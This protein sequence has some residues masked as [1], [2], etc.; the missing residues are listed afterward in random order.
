[1]NKIA[2]I[3]TG[4]AGLAVCWH[5]K[6]YFPNANIDLFNETSIY[7]NTSGASTGLLHGFI[8]KNARKSLYADDAMKAVLPLL[9]A[10]QKN[11]QMPLYNKGIYRIA[12]DKAQDMLFYEKSLKHLELQYFDKKAANI[13]FSNLVNHSGILIKNA[14]TINPIKYLK[15][16]F[17]DLQ[18][19]SVNFFQKKVFPND[20]SGYD[21]E[22][23]CTGHNIDFL[24]N[25]FPFEYEKIKGQM[26]ICKWPEG[27]PLLNCSICG[28]GH[29]SLI[30]Q[31]CYL[32]STY[33]HD[34]VNCDVNEKVNDVIEKI[35]IFFPKVEKLKI[36]DQKAGIRI[37]RK[38]HYFP[39]IKK[40]NDKTFVFSCLGSRGL[41]YHSYLAEKLI[42]SIKYDNL[43]HIPKEC[44]KPNG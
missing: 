41:L 13:F 34:F 14:L 35:K 24:N 7:E 20:L 30:N 8:G 2:V 36:I 12:I 37:K 16:L 25:L 22:I 11:I 17:L 18:S 1:M 29:I 23:F 33:E 15:G 4:F 3:G 32:G 19:K 44:L 26:L 21:F 39:L 9:N 40:I 43:D 10:A 5:L 42:Q 6:K 28:N 38:G 27:L 31:I